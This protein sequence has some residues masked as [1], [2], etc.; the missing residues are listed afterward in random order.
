LKGALVPIGMATTKNV[1]DL[2]VIKITI[3]DL[4]VIQCDVMGFT[5]W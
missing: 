4:M 5:R 2:M 3:S 1:W